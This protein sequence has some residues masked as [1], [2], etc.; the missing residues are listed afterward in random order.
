MAFIILFGIFGGDR[1]LPPDYFGTSSTRA[2]DGYNL[3]IGVVIMM[4]IG[5]GYLM[6][7]LKFYGLGAVGFCLLVTAVGLQWGL[8]VEAFFAQ[9]WA[10][11]WKPVPLD[12]YTI[13]LVTTNVAAPLIS[14]GAVI[15]KV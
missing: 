3:Y 9:A 5:F 14:L 11:D 13:Y 6:T 10:N 4:L 7:F 8:L 1:M 15:G 12:L 2:M